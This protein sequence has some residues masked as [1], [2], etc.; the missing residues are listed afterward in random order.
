MANH[1]RMEF[2]IRD[3]PEDVHHLLK[4]R[5]VTEK[6]TLNEI[7]IEALEAFVRPPTKT[8]PK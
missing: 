5:A 7:I 8:R 4:I 2:R 3:L 6:K 1:M